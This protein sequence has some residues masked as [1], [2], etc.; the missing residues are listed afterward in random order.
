MKVSKIVL[1]YLMVLFYIVMGLAHL[2][3]P[4]QYL[5]IMPPWLPAQKFLV[6][7]SGVV[8]IVL[9]VL[10]IPVKTRIIAARLIIAML[11]VFF[12]VVH[13]PE[14]IRYYLIGH[15]YFLVSVIRLPLQLLFIAWAYMF[16]KKST[17]INWP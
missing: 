17:L 1:L 6:I 4:E 10:L 15:E 14:S 12:L 11:V 5:I 13:V 3:V 9:A 16:A 2:I 7:F 8:E